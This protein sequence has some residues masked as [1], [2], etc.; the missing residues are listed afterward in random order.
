MQLSL[1]VH[2]HNPFLS[3]NC[4][5]CHIYL[6]FSSFFLVS[7]SLLTALARTCIV[8]G[9][10]TA[11]RQADTV[12]NATIATDIHQALDV[13]LN[14]GT[15]VSLYL[16]FSTDDFTDLS[17]LVIGPILYF[18]ISVNSGLIQNLSRTTTAYTI[19]IGQSDFASLVLRQIDTNNSY[20]HIFVLLF[21]EN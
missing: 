18:K 17:G 9:A 1:S 13:Q 4:F 15:E 12:A 8:L 3:C 11:Y 20:C 14:L 7:D 5:L 19:D 6:L 16:V 10:L 2:F 21:Y